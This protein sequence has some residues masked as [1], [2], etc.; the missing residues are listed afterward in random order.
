M[1]SA[2][3]RIE[4]LGGVRAWR[5]DH[6]LPL[7]PPQQ[8]D[9]FALLAVAGGQPVPVPEIAEALWDARPPRSAP[10]VVQ[11]Y[12]KRL[13][14]VL[15]PQRPARSPSRLLPTVDGGYALR[16][17]PEAVDLW[18]FRQ[19][20][21]LA[22][23]ARRQ[24]D[25]D[26]VFALLAD[27][28]TLWKGPPG[29]NTALRDHHRFRAVVEEYGTAVGRFV[30]PALIT[31][32]AAEALP[33]VAQASTARPL[34]EPL[35]AHLIRLYHATGRRFDAVKVFQAI[36]QRLRD[37]LDLDPGVELTEA[38]RELLNGRR[39]WAEQR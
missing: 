15:E 30:T 10:N 3:G 34:D 22:D 11:T 21:R 17:D 8:R 4:V 16:A 20:I 29:G 35:H 26:R 32:A 13:R 33:L 24:A 14:K 31:G 27:A 9:V 25:H 37:E 2:P 19:L 23:D 28:L 18:R 39:P 7:G 36:R 1:W 12:V 5:G 38:Y 6:E